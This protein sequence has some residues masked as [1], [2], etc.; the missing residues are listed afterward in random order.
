MEKAN[1]EV[2][3]LLP[4]GSKRLISSMAIEEDEK[5]KNVC[6]TGLKYWEKVIG[7]CT[8][9]FEA[10]CLMDRGRFLGKVIIQSVEETGN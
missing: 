9:S 2:Y 3:Q 5:E 1:I 10:E 6:S 8:G 7:E 4:D